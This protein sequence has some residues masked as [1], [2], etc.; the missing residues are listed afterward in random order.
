MCIVRLVAGVTSTSSSSR[1]ERERAG[2][3]DDDDDLNHYHCF[4]TAAK[5]G[6]VSLGQQ[7]ACV[8]NPT[9][10]TTTTRRKG[11][12]EMSEQLHAGVPPPLCRYRG[13]VGGLREASSS[14]AV[15]VV[16][17]QI[18]KHLSFRARTILVAERLNVHMHEDHNVPQQLLLLLL[19]HNLP[20][21]CVMGGGHI[22]NDDGLLSLSLVAP[23]AA[24]LMYEHTGPA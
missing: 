7:T 20:C 3:N 23:L 14:L 6:L 15:L 16:V 12:H 8:L 19:V 9:S 2:C 11:C 10:T 17:A 24:V 1:R 4:V 18:G 5:D 13:V 21:V 22:N